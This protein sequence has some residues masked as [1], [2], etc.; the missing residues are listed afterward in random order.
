MVSPPHRQGDARSV[1]PGGYCSPREAGT[2]HFPAGLI[3][4]EGSGKGHAVL[5]SSISQVQRKNNSPWSSRPPIGT[6]PAAGSLFLQNLHPLDF[7][8]QLFRRLSAVNSRFIAYSNTFWVIM[9]SAKFNS[10]MLHE[11]RINFKK[12]IFLHFL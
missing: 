1:A 12:R 10:F 5:E 11:V 6:A 8:S 3:I 7:L 4:A 2:G 9:I